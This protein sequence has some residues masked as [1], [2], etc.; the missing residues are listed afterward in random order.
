[1]HS[2]TTWHSQ[3][4]AYSPIPDLP[5]CLWKGFRKHPD[6]KWPSPLLTSW[7]TAWP[8]Q[9]SNSE[10]ENRALA[11]FSYPRTTAGITNHSTHA[12]GAYLGFRILLNTALQ[13]TTPSLLELMHKIKSVANHGL[14]SDTLCSEPSSPLPFNIL[15]LHLITYNP[16]GEGRSSLVSSPSLKLAWGFAQSRQPSPISCWFKVPLPQAS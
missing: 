13:M 6:P 10:K 9:V 11:D 12:Q 14:A 15:S 1:M 3:R 7:R 8:C 4:N 16:T 5:P 2:L